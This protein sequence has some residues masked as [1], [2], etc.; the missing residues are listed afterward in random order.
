MNVPNLP[1]PVVFLLILLFFSSSV[2]LYA[3][4]K[5]ERISQPASS[6]QPKIKLTR[7]ETVFA[8][9]VVDIQG[10]VTRPGVYEIK[11]DSRLL[12]ALKTAGGLSQS[13]NRYLVA[14]SFNLA[15]SLTDGEKI[16]IPSLD[17]PQDMTT[18][19]SPLVSINS[20]SQT[21]LELLPGIGPVTATKII[22]RRPYSS[23]EELVSRK[24][25]GEKT[26]SRII[27]LITL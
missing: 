23:P 9:I 2:S 3:V 11:E 4:L 27:N 1:K 19:I 18:A 7:S 13:A 17:E 14:K 12:D 26:L 8:G 15:K 5:L 6:N 25:L 16:Y 24:A 20:G 22:E 21:Q 10:A